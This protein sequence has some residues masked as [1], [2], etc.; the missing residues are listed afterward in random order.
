MPHLPAGPAPAP[1]VTQEDAFPPGQ[2]WSC[3]LGTGADPHLVSTP[4]GPNPRQM[5]AVTLILQLR[6][7]RPGEA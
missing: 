6:K 7:Q 3:V 2:P 4:T 1:S 5:T